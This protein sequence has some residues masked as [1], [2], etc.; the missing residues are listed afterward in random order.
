MNLLGK[1]Y[2]RSVNVSCGL[3]ILQIAPRTGFP[4]RFMSVGADDRT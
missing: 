3:H 4:R 2:R 1:P